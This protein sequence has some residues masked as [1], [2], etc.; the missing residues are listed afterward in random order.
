MCGFLA[1]IFTINLVIF[2]I[3]GHAQSIFE[4]PAPGAMVNLSPSFTP[5]IMTGMKLYPDNPL[6]FDFIID[7]GDDH[8]ENEALRKESQKLIN[9]FMASLTVPE[10]EMWVNLS[11]YEKNRI[12]AD[13]ISQTEMG[14]DMLAQD[15]L[16]KQ[17][18]ASLMYP[19]GKIGKEFWAKVYQKVGNG[20]DRFLL[21]KFK[22]ETFNKVWIVPDEASVY[23]NGSS[24]FVIKS[25]LKV[26]LEEDY[27]ALS[28]GVIASEAKQS[29][30]IASL[31]QK[32]A[33]PRND[34]KTFTQIIRE[35]LIPAIEE[36]VNTGKN[37]SNLRQI[38][39]S[40][41]LATWYKKNLKDSFLAKAFIDQNKMQG[42][43]LKD[44]T[45]RE[46]IYAQ[47]LEAF[48][49]GVYDYVKEDYDPA[50]QSIIPKKYFSGGVDLAQLGIVEE[51]SVTS[52]EARDY[53]Q[54]MS[55]RS[56]VIASVRGRPVDAAMLGEVIISR[57][58][59]FTPD[60]SPIVI[61]A[62]D[63]K[64]IS[65]IYKR[66]AERFLK[67]QNVKAQIIIVDNL[68]AALEPIK[69]ARNTSFDNELLK[70]VITD[71]DFPSG[72]PD[73]SSDRQSGAY[74]VEY[75]N[76]NQ[77][78]SVMVSNGMQDVIF[79][80]SS[81]EEIPARPDAFYG[82]DK[83]NKTLPDVLRQYLVGEGNAG[84]HSGLDLAI[85]GQNT[86]RSTS[87]RIAFDPETEMLFQRGY[88]I[89]KKVYDLSSDLE[90]R[91]DKDQEVLLIG[92]GRGLAAIEMALRYPNVHITA[93]NKEEGLWD[94]DLIDRR[95]KEK[96]YSSEQITEARGRIKVVILDIENS[97]QVS[98]SLSNKNFDILLFEPGVVQYLRDKLKI[99]EELFN[100][101][102]KVNGLFG[103]ILSGIMIDDDPLDPKEDDE[104]ALIEIF[105]PA[106]E[107]QPTRYEEDNYG[108]KYHYI[109]LQRTNIQQIKIPFQ[110]R[111]S[112][113][114][115]SYGILPYQEYFSVYGP[116][117]EGKQSA[118]HLS[119][120]QED[121]DSAMLD[122]HS[123]LPILANSI[124]RDIIMSLESSRPMKDQIM[125][126]V[127]RFDIF[128][129][130]SSKLDAVL[131]DKWSTVDPV[132][133]SLT[134]KKI[135]ESIRKNRQKY[136]GILLRYFSSLDLI[137][138]VSRVVERNSGTSSRENWNINAGLDADEIDRSRAF[139]GDAAMLQL[140]K[141]M[142]HDGAGSSM[143][144]L[145]KKTHETAMRM[146]QRIEGVLDEKAFDQT[147]DIDITKSPQWEKLRASFYF[148]EGDLDPAN[149]E[150]GTALG[151][152]L[153]KIVRSRHDIQ[154]QF[155]DRWADHIDQWAKDQLNPK[156]KRKIAQLPDEIDLQVMGKKI[157]ALYSEESSTKS[158]AGGIGISANTLQ[159]IVKGQSR[160]IVLRVMFKI[161]DYFPRLLTWYVIKEESTEEILPYDPIV[162]DPVK[163]SNLIGRNLSRMRKSLD[164]LEREVADL[165]GMHEQSYSRL[166]TGGEIPR[167][168]TLI[169]LAK[170]FNVSVEQLL[171]ENIVVN[172]DLERVADNRQWQEL[173]IPYDRKAA[174]QRVRR[175]RLSQNIDISQISRATGL[176]YTF[177][178]SLENGDES[179][180]ETANVVKVLEYLNLSLFYFLTGKEEDVKE[181]RSDDIENFVERFSQ[182]LVMIRKAFDLEP[183]DLEVLCGISREYIAEYGYDP[184]S[185]FL[186][187][188]IAIAKGLK[189]PP[190]ILLASEEEVR[191]Y[192]DKENQPVKDED[193]GF[194]LDVD[195][196]AVGLHIEEARLKKKVEPEILERKTE[197]SRSVLAAVEKGEFKGLR[198]K[199]LL[200]IANVLEIPVFDL[201]TGRKSED[202]F[203]KGF[204]PYQMNLEFFGSNLEHVFD[205]FRDRNNLTWADVKEKYGI[206]SESIHLV[207]SGHQRLTIS[208]FIKIVRTLGQSVDSLLREQNTE[209][210]K[211]KLSEILEKSHEQNNI[212][213]PEYDLAFDWFIEGMNDE[214]IMDDL[215]IDSD[216]LKARKEQLVQILLKQEI[217]R[218]ISTG[219]V[220]TLPDNGNGDRKKAE[221]SMDGLVDQAM[222]AAP[223]G[224]DLDAA[225]LKLKEEGSKF[226]F[227]FKN[228]N[229]E[230]MNPND[231]L[232]I[233]PVII[234]IVPVVNFRMLLGLKEEESAEQ[235]SQ[236]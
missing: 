5:A 198:I 101:R 51:G 149:K 14:R 124:L 220:F 216:E 114:R 98:E 23:V 92:V 65:G 21:D 36:E 213:D 70:L 169:K 106:A 209:T 202:N 154:A 199:H 62:E 54:L 139:F 61:I 20:R 215:G 126:A 93:I 75:A 19:E 222:T 185:P 191:A 174:G 165:V 186:E 109:K 133:V 201:L 153:R 159:R 76:K 236:L 29:H 71:G 221:K 73:L 227:E 184:H 132:L 122:E 142:D 181:R 38:F 53:A 166:E 85:T 35:I 40:M 49:K 217:I 1:F 97:A 11:P 89:L 95:M 103:F 46:K 47:Y 210:F 72:D 152:E 99:F 30:E 82:K 84:N 111:E 230:N 15:Y 50:T 150:F 135:R 119:R 42:I 180:R 200:Q 145:Q 17:L 129:V 55:R 130:I 120:G 194:Y 127:R 190:R 32:K 74:L 151:N 25:H 179:R 88:E 68:K 205:E 90:Q 226:Q 105:S 187:N 193:Q 161:A 108:G 131:S 56:E 219:I 168:P 107:V 39:N 146:V 158:A 175:S 137:E 13:G 79:Q 234:N 78:P 31:S 41:I 83:I 63:D 18:T 60:G 218:N 196:K 125:E 66:I 212:S 128:Q 96:S 64:M 178:A 12:A 123:I 116:A 9:Y 43:D 16:L 45:I 167:Y 8:L 214:R 110:L 233:E 34:T 7:T 235:L 172:F 44:K 86:S 171:R 52:K 225:K 140:D 162:L 121:I 183:A 170:V 58:G 206:T 203:G 144:W 24:V 69:I 77:I 157:E 164:L 91:K 204:V 57:D 67:E 207:V 195:L 87:H 176:G 148:V 48:K 188:F 228:V 155:I 223:G 192:L 104:R 134:K 118:R 229:F 138:T 231:L 177:I 27:V 3:P 182:N 102:V 208:F 147:A 59:N 115:F 117:D 211:S 112:K 197:I 37:F 163:S 160:K 26:L 10:K 141:V 94:D 143:T 136:I 2:P 189:V 4:L 173:S 81:R 6:Q 100:Q 28:P 22:T 232:G 113:E 80:T 224:I 33:S 156:T